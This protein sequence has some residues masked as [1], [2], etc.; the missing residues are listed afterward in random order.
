M[1]SM[2]ALLILTSTSIVKSC[3]VAVRLMNDLTALF[4]MTMCSPA[5]AIRS[6]NSLG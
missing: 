6:G 5:T 4:D 2:H 3:K 1:S